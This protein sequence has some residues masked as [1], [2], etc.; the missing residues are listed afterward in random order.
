[1]FKLTPRSIVSSHGPTAHGLAPLQ[2]PT[3]VKGRPKKTP[4]RV[5]FEISIDETGREEEET[6]EDQ[7]RHNLTLSIS[8][9]DFLSMGDDDEEDFDSDDDDLE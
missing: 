9:E 1:M 8:S 3:D 5:E 6:E 2:I 4:D 7:L